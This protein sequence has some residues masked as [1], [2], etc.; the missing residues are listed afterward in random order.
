MGT[1][2]RLGAVCVQQLTLS[3]PTISMFKEVKCGAQAGA[4][5]RPSNASPTPSA[6]SYPRAPLLPGDTLWA[7]VP[8]SR[9]EG[10]Q[11]PVACSVA[12][13]GPPWPCG[14]ASPGHSVS[15][16]ISANHLPC[17]RPRLVAVSKTDEARSVLWGRQPSWARPVV[18]LKE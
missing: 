13:L 11:G 15:Q 7:R 6:R 14:Q 9:R 18:P 12:L 3:L 17:A 8:G 4:L 2:W 1:G 16:G 10:L 5:C